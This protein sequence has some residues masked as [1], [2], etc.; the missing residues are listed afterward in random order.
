M[1]AFSFKKLN[2]MQG[3]NCIIDAHVHSG[4]QDTSFRQSFEDY[5]KQILGT[6]IRGAVVFAP[7]YEIY[8]R[9][10]PF[11]QDSPEWKENRRRANEYVSSLKD[12]ELEVFPYFFIWNDFA[13]SQIDSSFWG[14]KWHRHPDEPEYN[15]DSPKCQEAIEFIRRKNMPVV[16]EE[17]LSNTVRFVK[18]LA[19]GVRVII[20][21]LGAMN[22]GYRTIKENGIWEQE[23]VYTDTSLASRDSISDY[24]NNY[25]HS[26]IM[27][28][29]DFPFGNPAAELDKLRKLDLSPEVL[30]SIVGKNIRALLGEVC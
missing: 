24:L 19:T 12:R 28:G 29:S 6:E 25:G 20:P 10:D 22:G 8:D 17:E 30:K 15:Y 11:F 2:T 18:E 4:I 26:S 16:L 9:F 5:Q 7:V 14:I 3:Q 23:N 13:V 27:F 21:H 1:R